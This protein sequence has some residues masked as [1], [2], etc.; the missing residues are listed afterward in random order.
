MN[1]W[2]LLYKTQLGSF[3]ATPQGLG[4]LTRDPTRSLRSETTGSS[5]LGLHHWTT[6]RV[7]WPGSFTFY[8]QH[9]NEKKEKGIDLCVLGFL[10]LTAFRPATTRKPLKKKR[11]PK[12]STL[13]KTIFSYTAGKDNP[14]KGK[15]AYH[16]AHSRNEVNKV[17]GPYNSIPETQPTAI[18]LNSIKFL[19]PV[20]NTQYIPRQREL[21][22]FHGT[23]LAI[24]TCNVLWYFLFYSFNFDNW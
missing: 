16:L 9:W 21:K 2:W 13:Y 22:Q 23:I 24:T 12:D 18:H 19:K 7:P 20:I 3:L 11:L 5:P 15:K 10:F 6:S 8:L 1:P 4:S 14:V 17:P